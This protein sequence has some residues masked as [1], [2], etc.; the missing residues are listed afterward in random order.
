MISARENY[1][2][3]LE[4]RYPE[5]IPCALGCAQAAWHKYRE[6]LE[7]LCLRHPLLFPDF[8]KGSV[9]FDHFDKADDRLNV[10]FGYIF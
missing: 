8:E 9:D 1:L 5:W 7:D 4:F 6:E 10:L 2:R 3:T